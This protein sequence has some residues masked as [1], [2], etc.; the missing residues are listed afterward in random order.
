MQL[1][2]GIDIVLG[3]TYQDICPVAAAMAYLAVRRDGDGRSLSSPMDGVSQRNVSL[4]VSGKRW[5]RL[6]YIAQ[7]MLVMLPNWCGDNGSA[8]WS[9]RFYHQDIRLVEE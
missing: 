1:G 7:T 8:S 2:R 4:A 5:R 6:A 9:R 3:R